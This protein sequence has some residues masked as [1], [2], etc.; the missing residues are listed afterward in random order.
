MPSRCFLLLVASLA[1]WSLPLAAG[2]P[3]LEVGEPFPL[4]ELPL[5]GS[6]GGT[7]SVERMRGRKVLLHLFA[8]W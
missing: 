3:S 7:L 5:A 1:G 8:S 4:V 6:D 2:A